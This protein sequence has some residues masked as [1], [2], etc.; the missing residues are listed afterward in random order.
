M[1]GSP[2]RKG[3]RYSARKPLDIISQA[4]TEFKCL[5]SVSIF[6]AIGVDATTPLR[7]KDLN[8]TKSEI[9]E[10]L[11]SKGY[12]SYHAENI[13]VTTISSD[14]K[15]FFFDR[16]ENML[17]LTDRGIVVRQKFKIVD[18]GEYGRIC[19]NIGDGDLCYSL[20]GKTDD[21]PGLSKQDFF[22]LVAKTGAD[23]Y[24]YSEFHRSEYRDEEFYDYDNVKEREFYE[25][26]LTIGESKENMDK[27]YGYFQAYMFT[28]WCVDEK[29]LSGEL[30]DGIQEAAKQSIEKLA[31]AE[32]KDKIWNYTASNIGGTIALYQA[33]LSSF[34]KYK[35]CDQFKGAA[36]SLKG[37]DLEN[38][39]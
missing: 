3:F 8:Y 31:H 19:A 16:N 20:Y 33:T 26:T 7:A 36:L 17:F 28:K 15:K 11:K 12:R 5:I 32:T 30:L 25:S 23:T 4:R 22:A 38:P 37:P 39:F 21:K 29:I 10:I 6:F 35:T 18:K 14:D 34:E 1:L 27:L 9:I 24:T 13:K 2:R